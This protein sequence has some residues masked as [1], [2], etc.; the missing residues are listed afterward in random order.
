[1]VRVV[2]GALIAAALFAFWPTHTAEFIHLDDPEYVTQNPLIQ[3]G[4]TGEGL[5]AAWTGFYAGFWSPVLWMSFMLD[6]ELFGMDAG[7]M[8]GVNLFWHILNALLLFFILRQA[9]GTL[10]RSAAV[11]ALFALHPLRVESVAWVTER[12]D[13]LSAFFGL[14]AIGCYL[15]YVRSSRLLPYLLTV[16][17]FALSLMTKPMLVTLP[18]LLLLM[19]FWPLERLDRGRIKRAV[20]EKLPLFFLSGLFSVLT[21]VA[22][23]QTGSLV[24]TDA[25]PALI[26][27]SYALTTCV[28]Y[29]GKFLWPSGLSF[30][31]PHSGTDQTFLPV[32][33][34]VIALLV[35]SVMVVRARRSRPYLL[36]GWLWFIVAL[37][38]TLGL[39]QAGAVA[40]ADRFTYIP[41]IGLCVAVVWLAVEW[42]ERLRGRTAIRGIAGAL[43]LCLLIPLTRGRTAAWENTETLS[44]NALSVDADNFMAATLLGVT[45]VNNGEDA[46]AI[47]LFR[48]AVRSNQG[49]Y[50]PY[51]HI[52]GLLEKNGYLDEAVSYYTAA[53][54]L[55]P[56]LPDVEFL[57]GQALQRQG[58]MDEALKRYENLIRRYPLA[59][60][61][62][63]AVGTV[64]EATGD[65]LQALRYYTEAARLDP[66]YNPERDR[67]MGRE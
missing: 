6:V 58:R 50:L 34:A 41:M 29:I 12:K 17:L 31:Y 4:W 42:T 55:D 3:N 39:I 13:V 63:H 40:R 19:D 14:S 49:F 59:P 8:R 35:A 62:H 57:L 33:G 65:T 30:F 43:I 2:Y 36:T 67:L 44:R 32:A 24:Q 11:A 46:E 1:M 9:T 54:R 48:K 16:L 26:R 45:L 47:E 61:L 53:Y 56:S 15:L 18:F 66:G 21:L 22:H 64:F 60:E 7:A 10:W 51:V 23:G 20:A 25:F 5:R 37:L 28:F 52:G 27:L 38:P